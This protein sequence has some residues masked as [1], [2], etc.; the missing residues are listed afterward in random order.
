LPTYKDLYNYEVG[1]EFCI[2]NY[3]IFT[4]IEFYTK[5]VILNKIITPT[6]YIYDI[7]KAVKSC[8]P[9]P[10]RGDIICSTMTTYETIEYSNNTFPYLKPNKTLVPLNLLFSNSLT[11]GILDY[12]DSISFQTINTNP[13][14]YGGPIDDSIA[15]FNISAMDG[16]RTNLIVNTKYG[17]ISSRL[18]YNGDDRLSNL[19]GFHGSREYGN[20][21]LS[22]SALIHASIVNNDFINTFIY[23]SI[24]DDFFI[25]ASNLDNF[26][27]SIYNLFGNQIYKEEVMNQNEKKIDLY[28]YSPGI[29]IIKLQNN[30]G[31]SLIT[32]IIKQ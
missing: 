4:P 14:Y 20:I 30:N 27:V 8:T 9:G 1:D 5:I 11:W 18:T 12:Q 32:K 26:N 22:D 24:T 29:Y 23:P 10:P 3:I 25:I 2:R 19:E 28:N 7:K 16:E 6:S 13:D 15:L 17:Y 31:Q 21:C